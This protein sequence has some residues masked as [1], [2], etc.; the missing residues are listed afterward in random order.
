MQQVCYASIVS[1]VNVEMKYF[2]GDLCCCFLQREMTVHEQ[3]VTMSKENL[4]EADSADR[5]RRRSQLSSDVRS[6][7]DWLTLTG[8]VEELSRLSVSPPSESDDDLLR[9]YNAVKVV[10]ETYISNNNNSNNN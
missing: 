2:A 6:L 7:V 9:R 5:E 3:M 10:F 1:S 4:P 8:I